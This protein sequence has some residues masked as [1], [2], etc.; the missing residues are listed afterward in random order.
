MSFN[1]HFT[2]LQVTDFVSKNARNRM[3]DAIKKNLNEDNMDSFDEFKKEL[4]EKYLKNDT[5]HDL[6][7]TYTLEN[8]NL[9]LKLEK[10]V[11]EAHK[12][13]V[14]RKKLRDKI[15]NQMFI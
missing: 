12:R 2:N 3:K 4:I 15:K 7:L 13:E 5:I 6:D 1:V 8:N 14:L 11:S 9:K 10:T